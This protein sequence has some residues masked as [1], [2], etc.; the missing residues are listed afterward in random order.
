LDLSDCIHEASR[1]IRLSY[2][3][4]NEGDAKKNALTKAEKKKNTHTCY[5]ECGC[6]EDPSFVGNKNNTFG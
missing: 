3:E 2:F 5:S 6:L 4:L 1:K